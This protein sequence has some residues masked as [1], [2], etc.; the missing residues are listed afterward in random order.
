MA[1]WIDNAPFPWHEPLARDLLSRLTDAFFE[2]VEVKE[3]VRGAKAPNAARIAWG[4]DIHRVWS[5]TLDRAAAEGALRDL[6]MFI[7]DQGSIPKHLAAFLS[8]LLADRA[9]ATDPGPRGQAGPDFPSTVTL[10][11]A[12]LFGEDLSEPVG[13]IPELLDSIGRV[14]RWRTSVCRLRVTAADGRRFYGTGTLL[15]GDRVLSN[16]HVLFPDGS[17]AIA[18]AVEFN[19]ED[20]GLGKQFAPI[21]I[22]GN[23]GT[24]TGDKSDDWAVVTVVSAPAM[25]LR[26]DLAATTATAIPDERAFIIQHPRG[27]S[28]R[29]AFVRNRVATVVARRVYYLTDT[30]GGSSGSPVFN[31]Q[32]QLIALHRAGGSP[33]RFVGLPPVRKNEGVRID[34]IAAAI[35]AL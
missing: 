7:N 19:A 16:H 34:I 27:E 26:F 15:K 33:Q 20:D 21:V 9:P 11:E 18:V 23:A 4:N 14:M 1:S 13:S 17:A 6:L 8:D 30:D 25:A 10:P 24:I 29:L 3:L 31:G 28:K 12:L 35:L 2:P 5:D 32:G 22:Q